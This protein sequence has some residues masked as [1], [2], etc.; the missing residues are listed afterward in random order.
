MI[1]CEEGRYCRQKGSKCIDGVK[2]DSLRMRRRI[3]T[4]GKK[5]KVFVDTLL[6]LIESE[7]DEE[8]MEACLTSDVKQVQQTNKE[9][10]NN[11]SDL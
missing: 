11:E 6:K 8:E 3:H 2:E 5:R 1:F 7:W 9:G 4:G 10:D